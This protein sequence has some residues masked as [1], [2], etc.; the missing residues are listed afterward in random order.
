[1]NLSSF[2]IPTLPD[3]LDEMN[4]A[5]AKASDVNEAID[6]YNTILQLMV[7]ALKSLKDSY[8]NVR[9]RPTGGATVSTGG[10]GGGGG[11]QGSGTVNTLAEFGP[12]SSRIRDSIISRTGD[13]ATVS[14]NLSVV[15]NLTVGGNIDA[16]TNELTIGSINR[17]TG[18]LTH[19]IGGTAQL[20]I[21]STEVTAERNLVIGSGEAT[22]DYTIT[23]NGENN[24]FLATWDDS[25]DMLQVSDSMLFLDNIPVRFGG[26]TSSWDGQL[27]SDGTDVVLITYDGR[28]I[29]LNAASEGTGE[30]RLQVADN[31]KI[32]LTNTAITAYHSIL[33]GGATPALTLANGSIT[34]TSGSISFG[35][36]NLL[37]TGT[38]GASQ[39]TFTKVNLGGGLTA[40]I[41]NGVSLNAI[42]GATSQLDTELQYV[43]LQ[44][45]NTPAAGSRFMLSRSRG[46]LAS[47]L[48]AENNDVLAAIDAAAYDGTDYVLAG[49]MDFEADGAT[50]SNSIY[51]RI[52]FKT[53]N[54]GVLPATR[55][56]IKAA[57]HLLAGTDGTG[58][59]NIQTGGNIST[60]GTLGVGTATVPHGGVGWAKVALEG[61]NA[62]S[63]GPHM[64][65]TTDTN[66]HPLM[67]ILNYSHDEIHIAFDAYWDGSKAKS[68][69]P[70]SN[71]RI[72]KSA[73]LFK[74]EYDS[75][76][77]AGN[78][79][80]WNNYGIVLN[81]SG[82]VG[83]GAVPNT[84]LDVNGI[85]T[86]RGDQINDSGGLALTFDGAG[87]ITTAST[88]GTGGALTVT[89]NSD[90]LVLTNDGTDSNIK[91]SDGDLNLTTDE[92]T[93]TNS[94]LHI[95]GKGTGYGSIIIYDEDDAQS[96]SFYSSSGVGY[97]ATNDSSGG[98]LRFQD[99]AH[100]DITMFSA[101]AEGETRELLIYGFRTDDSSRSLQI[102][103][104]TDAAD[105]A[106]FDGVSNYLFDGNLILPK[107][108][109]NGIKVDTATPTFGWRDIIGTISN[110]KGATKATEATYRDGITQFQ[111]SAG[112][113]A[114]I[115][116]HI[117]HDYVPGTDIH[118]HFHW[119]HNS[120]IVTGGSI[121]LTYEIT[122][123]KGHNQAAFPATVTGTVTGTASTTQYQH[124]V[125]EGQI[126]AAS[127]SAAQIDSD[128]LEPDG[129]ILCR[130][131][132]TTNN[133]TASNG[134]PDPFIH[135]VDVHYQSTNIGTKQK[136]PDFYT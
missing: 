108:S 63:A 55:W 124:I 117:P 135:E 71:Y 126:S 74:I 99:T 76:I 112:D 1:M 72:H 64:Q 122:Y 96:L 84:R 105:T 42:V 17:A 39:A 68:S 92:G 52:L 111:F 40:F 27:L 89:E 49:E 97:I 106:S 120:A 127:P 70:G 10:G 8:S 37:T 20:S 129:L 82:N 131:E 50:A 36:E 134:V 5:G 115:E 44:H 110:S 35:D 85:L 4:G 25:E 73:D 118:L 100:N 93:N 87:A 109:G 133:M 33:C 26:T 14:N 18:T 136:A 81:T 104:G 65:F 123:A 38:I 22:T 91:W 54:G 46:T 30:I 103:V 41:L 29:E 23:I 13:T 132:M 16:G 2:T 79:L 28:D 60:T 48:K 88:L 19:E 57:G 98:A 113:D 47:P 43:A 53:T 130:I 119:S 90:T 59:Y 80:T 107:T 67:Q 31:T 62:D 12:S 34:D 51:G 102:G 114:E 3:R 6:K 56:T 24:D 78:D 77:A 21:T 128:N 9:N 7:K 125:S 58:A 15:T 45:S 66:D 11:V 32:L 95:H 75:G 94:N 83:I 116:Y 61:A 121:V 69:D 101:T 86:V